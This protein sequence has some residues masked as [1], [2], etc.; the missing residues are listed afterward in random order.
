MT[1]TC[2]VCVLFVGSDSA[3]NS[4]R[5]E[6]I[7]NNKMSTMLDAMFP[8]RSMSYQILNMLLKESRR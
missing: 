8:I 2:S 4:R 7:R 1:P 3:V 6:Y 5:N